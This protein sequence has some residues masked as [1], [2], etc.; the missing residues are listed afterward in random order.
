MGTT[1]DQ[2]AAWCKA[3]D[4]EAFV[5]VYCS[6]KLPVQPNPHDYCV[7]ANHSPCP[8]P[9]GGTHWVACRVRGA[10]AEWFDSYGLPPNSVVEDTLMGAPGYQ[11]DFDAWLKSMRV[12][13][14]DY[15]EKDVQSVASEVCG[16]Y[17]CYFAKHGL[18]SKNKKAWSFLTRNVNANDAHIKTLV[19]VK[20][21]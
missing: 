20:Q 4:V 18:P 14:L 11:P 12:T 3:H 17:A 10:H 1:G 16:L 9:S 6:N 13:S 15:N 7:I 5:G 21:Q 8:S 19:R 2:L